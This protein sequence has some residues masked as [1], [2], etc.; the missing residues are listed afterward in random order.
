[1]KSTYGTLPTRTEFD[2]AFNAVCPNGYRIHLGFTD[3][4]ATDG[5]MLGDGTFTSDQL[6]A[7]IEEI[8]NFEGDE[9][10]VSDD[11]EWENVYQVFYP[12]TD[13]PFVEIGPDSESLIEWANKFSEGEITSVERAT[14]ALNFDSAYGSP[15]KCF[16]RHDDA[17]S[18]VSSIME[19]LGFEWI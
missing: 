5:F 7:A 3:S 14:Q 6:W 1:M 19:T 15:G 17:M 8:I 16:A 2:I 18:L 9:I 10:T 4:R 12:G 13:R 11:D